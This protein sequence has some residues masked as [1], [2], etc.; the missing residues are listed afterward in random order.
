[1]HCSLIISGLAMI[2]ASRQ[3]VKARVK[4]VKFRDLS[5]M[6]LNYTAV[7]HIKTSR[8]DAFV[9]LMC[10]DENLLPTATMV[11]SLLQTGTTAEI[12]VMANS[13][14][15]ENTCKVL[16]SLAPQIL[17][18]RV[19]SILASGRGHS[20]RSS[21]Y[22]R[23]LKL[24]AWS[25]VE[26]KRIVYIDSDTLVVRPLDAL[27]SLPSVRIDYVYAVADVYPRVFN[28]GL[29]LL[30][31]SLALFKSLVHLAPSLLSYNRGDQ[32]FLNAYFSKQ[33]HNISTTKALLHGTSKHSEVGI[34]WI[35]LDV[36]YNFPAWLA[37]SYYGKSKYPDFPSGISMFHFAG[38]IKPWRMN[39]AKNR[40][41]HRLY[42]PR[43]YLGWWSQADRVISSICKVDHRHVICAKFHAG[44]FPLPCRSCR[45][46]GEHVRRFASRAFDSVIDSVTVMISTFRGGR[47]PL[48]T[49]IQ[50]YSNASVVSRIVIVWHDPQSAP[51]TSLTSRA[52]IDAVIT[53]MQQHVDSLNN[54]FLPFDVDTSRVLVCDDDVLISL[55][56]LYF[57]FSI[58]KEN[59]DRLVS[60]FV[61]SHQLRSTDSLIRA[62]SSPGYF[63]HDL[64]F[65]VS[66]SR[67]YSIALTKLC[68]IPS[69]LLFVYSCLL[70]P[71]VYAYVDKKRNCEDIAFNILGAVVGLKAP[72]MVDVTVYDFGSR[73]GLSARSSHLRDRNAC[74]DDLMSAFFLRNIYRD[75]LRD[76]SSAVRRYISTRVKYEELT[77]RVR[78]SKALIAPPRLILQRDNAV[79]VYPL[80]DCSI[81]AYA[82]S[83]EGAL[84]LARNTY[85]AVRG[86][87]PLSML[88]R[89]E[90]E[91]LRQNFPLPRA[92]DS[93]G[94]QTASFPKL[95]GEIE[96]ASSSWRQSS[97]ELEANVPSLD[98]HKI[99][100]RKKLLTETALLLKF[101]RQDLIRL[102]EKDEEHGVLLVDFVLK[103]LDT[104]Q[105]LCSLD[106][107]YAPY[108][109]GSWTSSTMSFSTVEDLMELHSA[110]DF[111]TPL[112]SVGTLVLLNLDAVNKAYQ[113]QFPTAA[114]T[115]PYNL[116]V[117]GFFD[118]PNMKASECLF[119]STRGVAPH[120]SR[121]VHNRRSSSCAMIVF[122]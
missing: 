67:R 9:T 92:H 37:N 99:S 64:S 111:F 32:G 31:P 81:D 76:S 110:D 56:D 42:E 73:G 87:K 26:Y 25:L 71:R 40:L 95:N 53:I 93:N 101:R 55:D 63:L 7:D 38:E 59:D 10:D 46:C 102:D 28:S 36:Q 96:Y 49:L 109:P 29:M 21:Q 4:A 20:F 43:A 74:V 51:P 24:N 44:S 69:W 88:P 47:L 5:A 61:R 52:G 22:C 112:T 97:G 19:S 82:A 84:Q 8:R 57:T 13:D 17:I 27:F 122:L 75:L 121:V 60:P 23:Y 15:T 103:P 100:K 72:L 94:L 2:V 104:R 107:Y 16:Q 77:S 98:L 11:V 50:H 30:R 18:R 79:Y 54:R 62:S 114:R 90:G 33:W 3:R 85:L 70:N 113:R 115:L 106:W 12:V 83:G 14:V 65:G 35:P 105:E 119:S 116:T 86:R 120:A 45:A 118:D 6:K 48:D 91:R 80:E 68:I 78:R 1:M 66:G 34:G 89:A 58:A 117:A 39:A 41:W 108:L